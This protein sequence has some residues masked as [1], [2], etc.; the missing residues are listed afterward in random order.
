MNEDKDSSDTH[1][2]KTEDRIKKKKN[3]NTKTWNKCERLKEQAD[4]REMEG[5]NNKRMNEGM[6]VWKW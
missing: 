3:K 5:I 1:A 2:V 6:N 4:E